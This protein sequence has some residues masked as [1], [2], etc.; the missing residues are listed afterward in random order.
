KG[1][2]AKL[3]GHPLK[4]SEMLAILPAVKYVERVALHSPQSVLQTKKAIKQAFEN[5]INN[6]GFSFVE[7]LSPCPTYW[8]LAPKEAM[9]WI[10]DVMMKEFPL[11][12]IK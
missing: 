10:K 8:G 12:K 11:G 1:R 5:Q 7:V 6:V 4:I 2:E 3:H 9:A